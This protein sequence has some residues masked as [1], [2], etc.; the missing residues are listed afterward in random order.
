MGWNRVF[1]KRPS[2]LIESL[3]E[4]PRFYFVHSYYVEVE[5]E[6]ISEYGFL[7]LYEVDPV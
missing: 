1:Q 3:G 4:E 5:N 2:P 6:D 7:F